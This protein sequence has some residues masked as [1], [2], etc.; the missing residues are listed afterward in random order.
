[1]AVTNQ[2]RALSTLA[3]ATNAK[4]KKTN[5]HIALNAAQIKE[6]AKK[7]RQAL[8]HAMNA[9]DNKM[10]NIEEE[11]KKGRSKLAAQAIA[12]DKK[13][14]TYANN[15][16]KEAVAQTAKEFHDVRAT[17]AKDRAHADAALSHA[18]SRMNAAL[19][20]AKLLQN[21]RFAQSVEDIAAAKKEANDRV[22]KFRASFKADILK[23]SGVVSEQSKKLNNRVTQL[24]STIMNN[25]LEQAKVNAAAD[26]ELKNMVKIGNDRYAEHL[27]KDKE[28][29]SLMEKNKAETQKAMDS[30]A[31]KFYAAIDAIKAQMKK[32]RASAE[33]GLSK[34]TG[35]LYDTLKKN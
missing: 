28:L 27:A 30:M 15:K 2:Q 9:F 17:M 24:S 33:A 16:I 34:E 14:R 1:M 23:L 3:A 19:N 25:K 18:S 13:F 11:A 12:M 5:K 8:D 35:A 31:L 10:N 22:A 6:N 4:I 21:K 20:A 26:K 7:A 32:D 29:K